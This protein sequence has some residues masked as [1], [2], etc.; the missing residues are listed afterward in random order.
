MSCSN[1]HKLAKIDPINI[2]LAKLARKK[3]HNMKNIY[4]PTGDFE[5]DCIFKLEKR[6]DYIN[7]NPPINNKSKSIFKSID[8]YFCINNKSF[9][10]YQSHNWDDFKIPDP[11]YTKYPR[12]SQT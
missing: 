5:D 11:I 8:K 3:L 9:L 7:N 12:F 10:Y 4:Y 1:L 6:G 2:R